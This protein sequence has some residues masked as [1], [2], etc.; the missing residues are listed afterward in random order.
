MNRHPRAP[1]QLL[2]FSQVLKLSLE[3]E[4]T[5]RAWCNRCNR[6]QSLQTRKT[7]HSLPAVIMLNAAANTPD[8][9][10][11]WD[12]P[13]CL[14]TE[15][16]LISDQNQVYCFQGDELKHHLQRGMRN[17]AVYSLIGF[18]ADID[19]G[20]H[21]KPHLVSMIDG[22]SY[23]YF[24]SYANIG[25]WRIRYQSRQNQACGTYSMIF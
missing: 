15:I 9:K 5:S 4:I 22:E 1:R 11:F 16:G 6:Y 8:A 7:I 23:S 3:R 19:S 13:G 24:T 14:P 17:I 20:Q 21:Q 12:T 18:V 25:K 10:Q 2:T